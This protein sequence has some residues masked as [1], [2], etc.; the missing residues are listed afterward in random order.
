MIEVVTSGPLNTVQDLGRYGLRN[1][2][3]GTSGAMDDPALRIGNLLVGNDEAAAGIE[4]QTFPFELRVER[5]TRVAVTGAWSDRSNIDGRSLLPWWGVIARAGQTLTLMHP[6]RG[7]RSYVAVGGGIDVPEVLGSRS[8]HLRN[9]FGGFEGRSLAKGDRLPLGPF[10]QQATPEMG[11]APPQAVMPAQCIGDALA[12]RIVRGAE[13]EVFPEA[14]RQ[15]FLSSDWK[16]TSQSD[17]TGYRLQGE[18]ILLAEPL[19]LRSYGVV[20]GIV[21]VPP[22]GH[23]IVQ[24]A[25]ANTAGGYPRIAGV[26]EADIWRLAQAPLG[27]R[28]HFVEMDYPSAV[29]AMRPLADYLTEI[30]GTLGTLE[31]AMLR[32]TP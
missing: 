30:R 14:A 24:M 10:S 26:I 13:F 20:A 18:P 27:S 31:G 32:R 28:I 2:G 22:S 1:I 15:R 3:I 21:Q 23:P 29:S 19:E 11:V 4:V 17:R 6:Q 8:T 5:E 12:I 16:I 25:D 9:G 7:A